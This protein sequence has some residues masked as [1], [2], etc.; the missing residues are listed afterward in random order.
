MHIH[1]LTIT[2]QQ[3]KTKKRRTKTTTNPEVL[4]RSAGRAKDR[5]REK[6]TTHMRDVRALRPG[7]E[8]I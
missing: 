3:K 8:T 1:E 6:A 2:K 5:T 7:G 4:G